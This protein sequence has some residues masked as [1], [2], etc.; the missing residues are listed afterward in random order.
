MLR[1]QRVHKVYFNTKGYSSYKKWIHGLSSQNFLS[2]TFNMR[3]DV[4]GTKVHRVHVH[5]DTEWERG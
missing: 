3:V 2:P 4:Q 1:I 5:L